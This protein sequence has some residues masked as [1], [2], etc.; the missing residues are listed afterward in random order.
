MPTPPRPKGKLRS[1]KKKGVSL[2]G[3]EADASNG[4]RRLY[5]HSKKSLSNPYDELN[6]ESTENPRTKLS[7]PKDALPDISPLRKDKQRQPKDEPTKRKSGALDQLH[8]RR[9]TRSQLAVP[10]ADSQE[11]SPQKTPRRSPRK[12]GTAGVSPGTSSSKKGLRSGGS[13]SKHQDAEHQDTIDQDVD[14]GEDISVHQAPGELPEDED[15]HGL[16][17][18]QEPQTPQKK[19]RG[20]PPKPKSTGRPGRPSKVTPAEPDSSMAVD[21]A[22]N[23]DTDDRSASRGST[24]KRPQD[25]SE[26]E[27]NPKPA[28]L[29]PSQV[30]CSGATERNAFGDSP[31][32][33]EPETQQERPGKRGR[34][35]EIQQ[36]SKRPGKKAKTTQ[37][38]Q[39]EIDETSQASSSHDSEDDDDDI[40]DDVEQPGDVDANRLLGQ[41]RRLKEIYDSLKN[42]G[43]SHRNGE[44]HRAN[45]DRDDDDVQ[46][47]VKLCKKARTGLKRLQDDIDSD[48]PSRDPPREFDQIALRIKGLCG[49]NDDF[50]TDFKDQAKATEIYFYLVPGLVKVLRDTIE[51]Y[52]TID[53]GAINIAHLKIV[54]TFIA[55]ILRLGTSADDYRRPDPGLAVVRPVKTDILKPLR[56]VHVNLNQYISRQEQNEIN[57]REQARE[58]AET[59]RQLREEEQ[60]Q[61][62][63]KSRNRIL[64]KWIGLHDERR[65]VV[66]VVPWSLVRHLRMPDAPVE[67]D[68]NG[69]PFERVEL[70][71]HRVGPHPVHI[72]RAKE[73]VWSTEEINAL[74]EGLRRYTGP[75]VFQDIFRAYCRRNG[76]LYY[77][78]VTEIVTIAADLKEHLEEKQME[79]YGEI[80]QWVRDIPVWTNVQTMLGQENATTTGQ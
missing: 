68:Q 75:Q 7:Q 72:K 17:N 39:A 60:E 36:S 80:E 29:R 65:H 9:R 62:K 26:V 66:G 24:S 57:A 45:V 20:R 73:Q 18:D 15:E 16:V 2:N 33:S 71:T 3:S 23:K 5:G 48:E 42:V 22:M 63:R 1:V 69:E 38:Q 14:D 41:G 10:D 27:M 51:V 64:N 58:D 25:Q 70:L 61:A 76:A 78:N 77:Y 79:E 54:I 55:L 74:L 43:L 53:E 6:P 50:P 30:P 11:Q 47:I 21:S 44:F 8:E 35:N 49:Q 4:Q 12:H 31:D 40:E 13:S 37:N 59:A 46:A 56:K 19:R 32:E 34:D 28:R 67:F 52:E